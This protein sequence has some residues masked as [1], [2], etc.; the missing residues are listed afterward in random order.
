ME[1]RGE[2]DFTGGGLEVSP[3]EQ[4]GPWGPWSPAAEPLRSTG[5]RPQA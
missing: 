1:A 4:K 2:G 3:N 5:R